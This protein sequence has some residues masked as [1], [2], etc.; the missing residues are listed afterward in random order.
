[1]GDQVESN[2]S[3]R[4]EN[5]SSKQLMRPSILEDTGEVLLTRTDLPITIIDMPP[6]EFVA[7][8]L[9]VESK[10]EFEDKSED[11][12]EEESEIEFEEESENEFEDDFED[13]S[14]KEFE[15]DTPLVLFILDNFILLI[16]SFGYLNSFLV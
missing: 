5:E 2:V 4:Y 7:Q 10:E 6:E 16:N 11:K 9:E 8:Q 3:Q 14:E 12:F 1:M 15:D 13:N